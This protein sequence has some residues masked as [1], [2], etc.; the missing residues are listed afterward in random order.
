MMWSI[1]KRC[2]QRDTRA[3]VAPETVDLLGEKMIGLIADRR[4]TKMHRYLGEHGGTPRV[5]TG[6][7]VWRGGLDGPTTQRPGQSASIHLASD[8]HPFEGLGFSVGWRDETE[9]QIRDRY[10]RPEDQFLGQRRDI[11]YVELAGQPGSL[12]RDDSIRV[13]HWNEHGVGQETILVFDDLDPVQEIAWDLKADLERRVHLDDEYC[14][15][16]GQHYEDPQ[17]HYRYG[18]CVLRQATMVENLAL[19]VV[20]ASTNQGNAAVRAAAGGADQSSI[21]SGRPNQ[22]G[23]GG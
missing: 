22:R 21:E 8:H 20:L 2:T 17:H 11:T 5:S 9:Q 18:V 19:L 13:E 12:G 15:V 7:R 1:E 10:H 6:L 14:T 4:V 3:F 23:G 16:H